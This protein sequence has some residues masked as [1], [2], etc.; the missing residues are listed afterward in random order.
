VR[1]SPSRVAIHLRTTDQRSALSA[2]REHLRD[3]YGLSGAIDE[4]C[5]A[6]L[7]R[8]ATRIYIGD[9][10]C[11]HRLPTTAEAEGFLDLAGEAGAGIT[12]LTPFLTDHDLEAHRGLFELLSSSSLPV[13]IVF[14]DLGFLCFMRERYP[15][16]PLSAGRLLGSGLKDP[17]AAG[18]GAG[19]QRIRD[20][21]A[22][23]Q[24]LPEC[25]LVHGP[26]LDMLKGFGVRRVERDL[27]SCEEGPASAGSGGAA[28]P[29]AV[30]AAARA[31]AAAGLELSVYFPY[32]YFTTGRVCWTSSFGRPDREKFLP[33]Q[34]CAR[35]C[36]TVSFA[37]RDQGRGK[38]PRIVHQGNAFFYMYSA[39][40]VVGLLRAA[41]AGPATGQGGG[42]SSLRLVYQGYAIPL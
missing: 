3:L 9:E 24:A 11:P 20:G 29:A 38:G 21:G 25:G 26:W 40:Q 6:W 19:R 31:A 42:P 22:E 12:L 4:E 18:W 2:Y 28:A 39:S 37:R 35:P 33:R 1:S 16:V 36:D 41:A 34:D 15:S 13:E 7:A 8:S 5:G 23:A 32:G 14:N 27:L 10:F 30:T 17:R